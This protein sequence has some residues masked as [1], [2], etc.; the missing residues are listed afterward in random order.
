MLHHVSRCQLDVQ[1]CFERTT[2][3][4]NKNTEATTHVN[5]NFLWH[6]N[7]TNVLQTMCMCIN[8]NYMNH[9]NAQIVSRVLKSV[10]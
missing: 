10:T 3:S 6:P 2:K 5:L 7:K 1:V 8:A 4:K 9:N